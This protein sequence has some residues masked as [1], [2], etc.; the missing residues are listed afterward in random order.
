M[1]NLKMKDTFKNILSNRIRFFMLERGLT[2]E[3][4]A[5][6]SGLSKSGMC[7]ILNGKKLPSAFTIAKICSGLNISLENFYADKAIREF[8]EQL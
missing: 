6:Q 2:A 7:E 3:A 8:I 4:L 1:V 5:Y